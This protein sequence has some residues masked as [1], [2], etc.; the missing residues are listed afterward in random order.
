MRSLTTLCGS[1]QAEGDSEVPILHDGVQTK[2][3]GEVPILCKSVL[4][5]G[6]GEAP[7]LHSIKGNGRWWKVPT[8]HS[9]VQAGSGSHS[10]GTGRHPLRGRPRAT[11]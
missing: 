2:S 10:V 5:G 1:A 6:D 8:L 9:G 11:G 7:A 3:D 4:A